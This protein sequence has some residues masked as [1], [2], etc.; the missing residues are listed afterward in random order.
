MRREEAW[1]EWDGGCG[2]A[3]TTIV[4]AKK[5]QFASEN[6]WEILKQPRQALIAQKG[7]LD[8]SII[9]RENGRWR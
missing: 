7:F 8:N 4:A 9:Q 5:K 3:K 1:V 2:K 6:S